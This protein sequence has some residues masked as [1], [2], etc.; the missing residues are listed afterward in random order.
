MSRSHK[1][2]RKEVR[3]GLRGSGGVDAFDDLK[4]V[5]NISSCDILLWG[6]MC[7]SIAWIILVPCLRVGGID[8]TYLRY[9][10]YS[11]HS[12]WLNEC[13]C[14]ESGGSGKSVEDEPGVSGGHDLC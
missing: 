7:G 14:L 12:V 2:E 4:G 6:R 13:L 11:R 5:R 10:R 1:R 3:W 8:M 9:L